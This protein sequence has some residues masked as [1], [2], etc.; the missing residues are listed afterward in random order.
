MSDFSKN[1]DSIIIVTDNGKLTLDKQ[2]EINNY[3]LRHRH[4]FANRILTI[5]AK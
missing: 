2:K 4:G 5:E 3:Q 1:I